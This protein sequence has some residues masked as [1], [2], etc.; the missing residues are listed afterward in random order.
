MWPF[1]E[2]HA[3]LQLTFVQR[4]LGSREFKLNHAFLQGEVMIKKSVAV[5]EIPLSDTAGI[6]FDRPRIQLET[7][8]WLAI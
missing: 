6:H 7:S 5:F 8:L 1:P 4:I 3:Q 2:P